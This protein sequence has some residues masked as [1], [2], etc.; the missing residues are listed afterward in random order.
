MFMVLV[1]NSEYK[2]YHFDHSVILQH[3]NDSLHIYSNDLEM[4]EVK[5]KHGYISNKMVN[6][7]MRLQFFMPQA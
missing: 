5:Q 6:A 1:S 3:S 7:L 4:C 2:L